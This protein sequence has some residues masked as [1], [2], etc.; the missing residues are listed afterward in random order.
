M[1][2]RNSILLLLICMATAN[3]AGQTPAGSPAAPARPAPLDT[4]HDP[5]S[6]EAAAATQRYLDSVPPEKRA[7]SDAYFEGGYWLQL[8][9]F[10]YGFAV[11]ALLLFTRMSARMRDLVERVT[12]RRPLQTLLYW[13]QFLVVT[14]IVFFPLTV[15]SGFFREHQYGLSTQTFPQ[16]L[17]DF[18][19]G[20]MVSAVMGG[21]ALI[22]LYGVLRKSRQWWL[23]GSLVVIVFITLAV[24]IAPI[25][26]D[27]LFNKYTRLEDPEI[28]ATILRMAQANGIRAG[29]VWVMDASRQSTRISANVRGLFGTERI[30]LNDNLLNRT[31]LPEIRAVMGHEIGH[32]A[33][34]HIYKMIIFLGIVILVAFAFV[35][36]ASDRAIF[37]WGERWRVSSAGDIASLPLLALLL[38]VAFFLMTPVTNS[39]IRIQESEADLFGLHASREPEGFAEVSLKLGDYRKLSPGPLEE[40]LFFDHPSGRSRILMAMRWKAAE[41]ESGAAAKQEK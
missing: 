32:Y 13:L 28:R 29:D 20:F 35:K 5:S 10:L 14:T 33:L 39:I 1:R 22:A 19:K 40:I 30:T 17:G 23:W 38:S 34:N 9:S 6:F 18:A 16:W 15:Y 2:I 24:L 31:S 25:Y 37:R 11:Y 12:S 21:L 8:W 4:P 27:P 26:I 41:M 3:L 7:K 36:W